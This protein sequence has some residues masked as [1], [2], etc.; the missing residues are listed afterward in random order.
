MSL[1]ANIRVQIGA[2]S[3]Q[4]VHFIQQKTKKMSGMGQPC[5]LPNHPRANL[6]VIEFTSQSPT[7]TMTSIYNSDFKSDGI[8]SGG[9]DRP[10]ASRLPAVPH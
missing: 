4:K 9:D 2:Q 3:V 7:N 1:P 5:L 8:S 6:L 10:P